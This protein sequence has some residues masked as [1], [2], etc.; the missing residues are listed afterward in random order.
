MC[1]LTTGCPE[2]Q[3]IVRPENSAKHADVPQTRLPLLRT[4]SCR[5]SPSICLFCL[6]KRGTMKS[7]SSLI[8]VNI[9]SNPNLRDSCWTSTIRKYPRL[10]AAPRIGPLK[11]ACGKRFLD[12]PAWKL[13]AW[14]A[15]LCGGAWNAAFSVPVRLRSGQA[16][17]PC[18]CYKAPFR[19]SFSRSYESRALILGMCWL[20]IRDGVAPAGAGARSCCGPNP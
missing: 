17:K 4:G 19:R 2:N 6:G 1:H 12:A 20:A 13:A 14:S 10:H 16:L 7:G 11:S 8:G 18:P 5:G 15:G 3:Q 9:T